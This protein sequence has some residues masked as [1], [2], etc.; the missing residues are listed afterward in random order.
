M[1]SFDRWRLP[2]LATCN[3]TL[4]DNTTVD[5]DNPTDIRVCFATMHFHPLYGGAALRVQRYALG[6]AQRGIRM[7]VFTQAITPKLL[8]EGV[9]SDAQNCNDPDSQRDWPLFEIMDGLPVQRTTL[10]TDWRRNPAFFR[11]VAEHCQQRRSEIDVLHFN[12]LGHWAIPWVH[13]IRRLGIPTIYMATMLGAF[14]SNAQRRTWQRIHRRFPLNLVDRVVVSSTVMARYF[15]RMGVST[16]IEVIPNGVDLNR[17]RPIEDDG[18][19]VRL[20][21]GLGLSPGWDIV[22]G[23]GAISPRKGTDILIESFVRSCREYRNARLVLVGPRH[24]QEKE[25]LSGFRQHLENTIT[26]AN[27]QERVIFTGNVSNVQ[28]YLRAA[29]LLVFPSRREGMGNV[30]AEAMACGIPVIMTP[31]L[32]LPDEF[33]TPGKHYVLSGWEPEALAAD[34]RKLLA[35]AEYRRNLGHRGRH[36]VEQKLDVG[37]SLDRYASM[38][39]ELA[40]RRGTGRTRE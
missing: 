25:T 10:P 39:F 24:D 15:I 28:D 19:K 7:S 18:K 11:R 31:F 21:E 32:G 2:C 22:L 26:A 20:R 23:I 14:S 36:W 9:T 29:D 33:G 35:S 38:Y 12:T 40:G 27:I 1:A 30:V 13:R 8:A 6:L 34:I 4:T 5:R 17:F 37:Q 3:M 16:Q